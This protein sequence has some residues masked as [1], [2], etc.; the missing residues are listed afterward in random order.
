MAE[1]SWQTRRAQWR[2]YYKFCEGLAVQPLPCSYQ[3]LFLYI[4]FMARS[5]KYVTI[6]NYV[7]AVRMLHKLYGFPSPPPDDFLVK[8]TL[9][10]A[11]R[12]FGD[13]C[14]ASDPLLRSSYTLSLTY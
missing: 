5:F 14:F 12:L 11:R 3:N 7:S 1:S 10:G 13:T 6:I 9:V 8:S 2:H 4:A